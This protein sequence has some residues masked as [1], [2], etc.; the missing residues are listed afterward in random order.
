MHPVYR[1]LTKAP[2]S[3]VI[4]Q[5]APVGWFAPRVDLT[6]LLWDHYGRHPQRPLGREVRR[7][8]RG[9]RLVREVQ[10]APDD[11]AWLAYVVTPPTS[12]R[13]RAL[14]PTNAERILQGLL[15]ARGGDRCTHRLPGDRVYGC[16]CAVPV[17]GHTAH[18]CIHGNRW[19]CS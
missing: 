7:A 11:W 4:P 14:P 19:V 18:R 2:V 15:W 8:V 12:I 10:F 13:Q 3:G 5:W 9:M 6:Y 16:A 17:A 1:A